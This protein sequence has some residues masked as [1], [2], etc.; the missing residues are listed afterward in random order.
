MTKVVVFFLLV[1]DSYV[2]HS[3]LCLRVLSPSLIQ[4]RF[5]PGEP[6]VTSAIC[7]LPASETNR[8][9]WGVYEKQGQRHHSE[10]RQK[11]SLCVTTGPVCWRRQHV[12]MGWRQETESH[13][14]S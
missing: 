14:L 10:L 13:L 12:V 9:S 3:S 8:S 6:V 11:G 5:F 1:K 2:S 7:Q 4:E